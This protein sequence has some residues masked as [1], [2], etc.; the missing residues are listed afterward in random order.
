MGERGVPI[1]RHGCFRRSA[2]TGDPARVKQVACGS[3]RVFC[4]AAPVAHVSCEGMS[5]VGERHANLMQ[6]AGHRPNL[7]SCRTGQGLDRP[8]CERDGP[9]TGGNPDPGRAALR[10]LELEVELAF[11]LESPEHDRLVQLLHFMLAESATQP[12]PARGFRREEQH[13]RSVDI[14]TMDDTAAQPALA[15]ADDL[16]MT[17]HY[18][19]ERGAALADEKRVHR[20][21]G[22]LVDRQPARTRR[23]EVESDL[24]LGIRHSLLGRHPGGNLHLTAR[25]EDLSLVGRTA[26]AAVDPHPPRRQ[27]APGL[28]PRATERL[29][30][31]SIEPASGGGRFDRE[32][33]DSHESECRLLSAIVSPMPH[34]HVQVMDTTLR[35]GEQTPGIAYLPAEKLQLARL[36]LSEVGVDRI[37]I[38]GTRVSL[39]EREAARRIARWARREK[40]L[41]RL[42]ILGYCDGKASVDWM[43]DVGVKNMNLLVKGSERH[44]LKQLGMSPERHRGRV[45][46]TIRYA[47]KRRLRVN[48]YL[49]DWSSGVQD[50]FDYVFAMMK[51]LTALPVERVYLADT[52]GIFSPGDVTRSVD[53]MVRTWPTTH[54]EYHGHNDYGLATANCLAA[55]EAGARGI[56]TSVN[57][58][59]ERAGNTKLA[60]IVAA[61]HDHTEFR[62]RVDEGHLVSA[63]KLVEAFSGKNVSHNA[64]IV[65]ADVFTQTA[66]IHADGDAKGDLYASRLAPGRFG[67]RR[68][69][70]LGKLSGKASLDQNLKSL[71]IEL[72]DDARDLVL[73]RIVELGDKKHTVVPEDLRFVIADVLKTPAD[74]LVRI[75]S[76]EVSIASGAIP[77]ATVTLAFRKRQVTAKAKGDGGYDAFMNALKKAA[78]GFRIT[79]PQLQDFRV[80][81]PPGGRTGA[82]VETVIVWRARGDAETFS[83]LGVDSDQL[84]AAVIAT[85]KMLNE[86]VARRRRR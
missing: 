17:R 71:G 52:L 80:R 6:E 14:E 57:G 77:D 43:V 69:Y 3:A 4:T 18:G 81:I 74:Q 56:H 61:L 62:T 82:L 32:A 21:S 58:M 35:D 9:A 44:C 70:A 20:H 26:C 39:G 25:R 10:H 63:S 31:T 46:E 37:E 30:D 49:E 66:G 72:A 75:D 78:K 67:Q 38:A 11:A 40:L 29:G 50:S 7:D 36:L 65:G 86:V 28:G 41:D 34:P 5:E 83:T 73:K 59:G 27:H 19:P 60:E 48:V 45:A 2:R 85:E 47:R 55:V 1:R 53:L 13:T 8:P 22:R 79:V 15:D 76:Y 16:R 84:A 33:H 64:P 68:R 12:L 54:F 51:E 23:H 42:E 24:G